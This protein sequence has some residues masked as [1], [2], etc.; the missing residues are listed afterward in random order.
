MENNKKIGEAIAIVIIWLLILSAVAGNQILNPIQGP[1]GDKGDQGIQGEQGPTGKQG[2]QGAQGLPGEK[3]AKGEKGDKGDT[4]SKGAQGPQGPAGKSC[5]C[6]E[7]PVI[8]LNNI[9]GYINDS[10]YFT[11]YC[12]ELNFSVYD[13]EGDNWI[14]DVYYRM[15]DSICGNWYLD[16]HFIGYQDWY[17]V[18]VCRWFHSPCVNYTIEWAIEVDDGLNLAFDFFNYTLNY[19]LE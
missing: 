6:N 12:Y 18:K 7:T 11:W 17:T 1:K 4:G 9:S 8:T 14:V 16:K 15:E 13:P 5:E 10:G 3:G 2:P 19:C